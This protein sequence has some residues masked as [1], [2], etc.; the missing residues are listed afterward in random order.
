M[1]IY[2]LNISHILITLCLRQEGEVGVF[3]ILKKDGTFTHI[4]TSS[5][6][7]TC[8]SAAKISFHHDLDVFQGPVSSV[9]HR[10]SSRGSNPVRI[11]HRAALFTACVAD[12]ARFACISRYYCVRRAVVMSYCSRD[13]T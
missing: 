11:M 12:T 8:T 3:Q 2:I 7:V 5:S 13:R 1:A 10:C 4:L 9:M 6:D